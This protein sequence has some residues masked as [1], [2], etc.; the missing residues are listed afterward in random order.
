MREK[1]ARSQRFGSI[2]LNLDPEMLST[3]NT[4]YI[5]MFHIQQRANKTTYSCSVPG[6][7]VMAKQPMNL[8]PKRA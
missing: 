6:S 7:H 1:K 8:N 2:N 3:D 5:P 4:I